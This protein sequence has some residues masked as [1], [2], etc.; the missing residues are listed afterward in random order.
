MGDVSVPGYQIF[1]TNKR[2]I[3]KSEHRT[4]VQHYP[5]ADAQLKQLLKLLGV[6]ENVARHTPASVGESAEWASIVYAAEGNGPNYC[7]TLHGKTLFSVLYDIYTVTLEELKDLRKASTLAEQIN[8]RKATGQQ[9]TQEDGSQEVR[10]RKRRATDETDETSKRAA[11]QTITSPALTPSSRMSSPE[12][13]SLPLRAAIMENDSSGTEATSNEEAVPGQIGKLP[14]I[15]LTSTTNL[16]QFRKQVQTVVIENFEFR[17]TRNGTSVTREPWRISNPLNPTSTPVTCP[18][19]RSTPN[20]KKKKKPMK[21]VIRHLPHN[22]PAED[23]SDGLV[24]LGF[25]VI[26]VKQKIVTRR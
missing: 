9:A 15:I 14:P 10:K 11:V 4:L 26:R 24:N 16:I 8:S 13:L 2:S 6:I 21:A 3:L 22:T 19:T 17:S 5:D 25:D 18:I 23:I 12:T 1:W 20:P 7:K